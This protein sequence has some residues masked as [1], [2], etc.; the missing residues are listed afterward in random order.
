MPKWIRVRDVQTGHTFDVEARALSHRRGVE[1]VND[2][3]RWPDLEGPRARPRPAKPYVGKDGK[4]RTAQ[5]M[6][7][8]PGGGEA[9]IPR[10]D[11]QEAVAGGDASRQTPDA[12]SDGGTAEQPQ[13][14]QTSGRRRAS[15]TDTA[16][17]DAP[18]DT[19]KEQQR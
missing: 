5:Y 9:F 15:R 12:T 13:P 8:D 17:A 2:P 14:E 4:A 1:P 7:D 10:S 18:A 6:V 11:G 3:E 16:P 19:S